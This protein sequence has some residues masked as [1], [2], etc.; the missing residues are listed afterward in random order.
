MGRR[1]VFALVFIVAGC[2]PGNGDES[3]TSR[4]L[5]TTSTSA[6]PTTA[7]TT[8]L[9]TTST[10][11]PAPATSTTVGLDDTALAYQEVAVVDF[12]VQMT[13]RPGEGL[14]YLITK[15]GRV[16]IFDGSA[17]AV[18]PV[19]DISEQVHDEG[20]RGLLSI[21][22]HPT[23][24]RRFYLHYSDSEGDTTVSEFTLTSPGEADPDSERV[25]LQVEQ[26]A[27]NHNGGMIQFTPEGSLLLGLGDGGGADDRFGNGQNPD[28]LLAGLV[29]L[30]LERC[31]WRMITSSCYS[32]LT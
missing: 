24:P 22:L 17:V 28:T 4:D 7:S 29:E 14:S 26:P 3:T 1:L 18:R 10:T 11:I 2:S 27:G 15:D 31:R 20:E 12:P 5:P 25:L 23:D 16:W 13:A 19:L 32:P 21:A 6:T 8:F 30:E 9:S